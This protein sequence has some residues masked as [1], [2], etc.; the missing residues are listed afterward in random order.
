MRGEELKWIE[1]NAGSMEKVAGIVMDRHYY[2]R[3]TP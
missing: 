3:V 2:G 1:R